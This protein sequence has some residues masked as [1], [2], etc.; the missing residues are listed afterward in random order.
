M[1]N[2]IHPPVETNVPSLAGNPLYQS[3][4]AGQLIQYDGPLGFACRGCGHLCCIDKTVLITPPE[5]ARIIW[6][7]RRHPQLEASL[8]ERNIRWGSLFLGGSSGL[9]VLEINFIP[10]EAGNPNSPKYCPFLTPVYGGDPQKPRWLNMAWCGI[11]EARPSVCRI[12]PLGRVSFD[13]GNPQRPENWEYRIMERCPGFETANPGDAV[14]PGY[15][16]PDSQQ[17]IQAWLAQQ[18]DPAQEEEKNFYLQ[19]VIPAFMQAHL[20]ASTDDCPE[21]ILTEPLALALGQIFYSPPPPPLNSAEDHS[22][23]MAWLGGL[24]DQV[25]ILKT[26]FGKFSTGERTES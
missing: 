26:T 11:R 12:F 7:L 25:A 13:L 1:T 24:R 14:P 6:Y 19:T 21:G 17:T 5:A 2:T 20:H 3:F 9:P 10:L 4:A 8:R 18:I 15:Q 22:I 23:I 16:P